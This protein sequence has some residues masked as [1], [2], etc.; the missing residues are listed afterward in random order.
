MGFVEF[1]H[2]CFIALSCSKKHEGCYILNMKCSPKPHV[3]NSWFP[4]RVIREGVGYV[5]G[6]VWLEIS[7]KWCAG[8]AFSSSLVLSLFFSFLP[9]AVCFLN[10]VLTYTNSSEIHSFGVSF[11]C[12]FI[13]S[14]YLEFVCYWHHGVDIL[15]KLKK[16][17]YFLDAVD[18]IYIKDKIQK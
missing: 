8:G 3:L 18:F 4:S 15:E 5:I 2:S 13:F 11:K 7:P 12:K 1:C 16:I 10:A 17:L 9:C 14:F 6:R